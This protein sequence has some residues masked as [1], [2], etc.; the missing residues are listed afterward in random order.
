MHS[1]EGDISFVLHKPR[2][3]CKIPDQVTMNKT[4][5]PSRPTKPYQFQ[6]ILP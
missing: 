6:A 3:I 1:H 2:V 4:F 5:D